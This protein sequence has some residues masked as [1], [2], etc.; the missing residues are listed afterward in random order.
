MTSYRLQ[1]TRINLPHDS[2]HNILLKYYGILSFTVFKEKRFEKIDTIIMADREVV[3][4][5]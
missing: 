5:H 4:S 3:V 1:L 2:L